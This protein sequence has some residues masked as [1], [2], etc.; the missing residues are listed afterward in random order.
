MKLTILAW[1]VIASLSACTTLKDIIWPTTV[2]CLTMPSAALVEQV[3]AIVERDGLENVFSDASLTALENLARD[4]GPEAV[5]CIIKELIDAYTAP[6]GMAAPPDKLA[7]AR[8]AQDFLNEHEIVV[9]EKT[10]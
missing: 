3:K 5:V 4:Y 2:K 6:T 7:A 10:Q 8:R 1:V 9:Q